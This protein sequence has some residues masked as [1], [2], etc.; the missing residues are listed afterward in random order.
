MQIILIGTSR[1]AALKRQDLRHSGRSA[2]GLPYV[3][4]LRAL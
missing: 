4:R 3:G 2:R 1:T